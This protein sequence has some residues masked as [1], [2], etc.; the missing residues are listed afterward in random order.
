M[1]SERQSMSEASWLGRCGFAAPAD[2]CGED[3]RH[4]SEMDSCEDRLDET[5]AASLDMVSD[6]N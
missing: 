1:K 2:L 6:R 3:K 4:N 5:H